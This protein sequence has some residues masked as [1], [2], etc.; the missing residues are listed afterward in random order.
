[1]ERFSFILTI[2]IMLLGPI[3]LIPAFAGLT[4]GTDLRFKRSVAIRGVLVASAMCALVALGGGLLV[5]KYE[6]SLPAVRI[7]GGLV[8]LIAALQVI[9]HK[10]PAAEPPPE[11]PTALQLAVSPLATP[12]IVPPAGVAVIL[13]CM[14]LAPVYPG[15]EQAVVI[16]LAIVMGLNFLVMFF[17]DQ[18][19]K[20]P[21]LKIILTVFGSILI[22]VQASFG[23][24]TM[25]NGFADLRLIPVP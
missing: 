19:L 22:F 2:F 17:I 4:K 24:D 15:T 12:A 3:K 20:T 1:M 13:I 18:V 8:L 6:I 7:A 14:M 9:F 25:L 5:G 10:V 23:I 16:C 21:G 11:S